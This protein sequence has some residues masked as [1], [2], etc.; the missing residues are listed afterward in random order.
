MVVGNWPQKNLTRKIWTS[1]QSLVSHL[2]VEQP[3]NS[4]LTQAPSGSARQ[5]MRRCTE[6]A[7]LDWMKLTKEK[8]PLQ[9][10]KLPARGLKVQESLQVPPLIPLLPPHHSLV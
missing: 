10:E 2:S 5:G 6:L 4:H 1:I 8:T 9:E 3:E 7:V